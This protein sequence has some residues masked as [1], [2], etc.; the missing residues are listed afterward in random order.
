M[1]AVEKSKATFVAPIGI[2]MALFVTQIAGVYYT[3]ASLNP[4]R[5]F[6]PCVAAANFQGYHWI[7]CEYCAPADALSPLLTSQQGSALSSVPQFPEAT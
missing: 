1:L 6:G 4:A 5:S 2:G 3:G 7:Y